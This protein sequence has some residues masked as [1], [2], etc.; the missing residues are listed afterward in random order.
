ML[1]GYVRGFCPIDYVQKDYVVQPSDSGIFISDWRSVHEGLNIRGKSDDSL[2]EKEKIF[3][4]DFRKHT[5]M[6]SDLDPDVHSLGRDGLH[7]NARGAD[8]V[9]RQVFMMMKTLNLVGR[10]LVK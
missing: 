9:A 1:R 8:M 4:E 7:L 2:C 10:L 3:I 6:R 5:E